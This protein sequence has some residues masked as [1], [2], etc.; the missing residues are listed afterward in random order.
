[1][2]LSESELNMLSTLRMQPRIKVRRQPLSDLR[3]QDMGA[4]LEFADYR[5]YM[6]GDD[7]RRLDW[8]Q[9][10]KHD[11]LVV[12]QYEQ[13]EAASFNL[14]MDLSDSIVCCG[15][16][17][18]LSVKKI[19][20]AYGF[21]ILKHG[22]KISL[23]PVGKNEPV[24]KFSS[25]SQWA[26]FIEHLEKIPAGGKTEITDALG[27]FGQRAGMTENI[28][29][30]SDFICSKGYDYMEN[31]LSRFRQNCVYVHLYAQSEIAPSF[32][33]DLI[34]IDAELQTEY[35]TT[36]NQQNIDAYKKN[37]T[38]Y[39]ENLRKFAA[40]SGCFY[41]DI[42]DELELTRQIHLLAPDGILYL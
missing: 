26:N 28:I 38:Q 3:S 36:I 21:V 35:S 6:P 9:F 37:Y 18:V 25:P 16:K 39:Y 20:A 27:I 34:L 30:V 32:T 11:K 2:L 19:C 23:L 8:H 31:I 5:Q 33:G 1:M 17:K 24:R 13:W 29:A 10:Q 22:Y 40:G 15:E 41:S 42:S 7:I 12:R 4:G 14:L